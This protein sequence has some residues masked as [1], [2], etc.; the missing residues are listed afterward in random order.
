MIVCAAPAYLELHGAPREIAEIG[1]HEAVVYSRSGRTRSWLFP[2]DDGPPVEVMP[3]SRLRLD[4]LDAIA[5]AVT[6][7][8]GLGWL[9]SWLVR[10]RLEAAALVQLLPEQ[11]EFPYDCHALWLQTPHLPRRVRLARGCAGGGAAGIDG[12]ERVSQVWVK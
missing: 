1:A 9:P 7:G 3:L 10:D 12:L 8:M 2:R 11:P 5:D 6:E 4:D